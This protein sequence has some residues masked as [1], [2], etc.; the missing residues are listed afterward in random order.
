VAKG[1]T[2]FMPVEV[3]HHFYPSPPLWSALSSFVS[4]SMVPLIIIIS[5]A[6]QLCAMVDC[7]VPP[8]VKAAQEHKMQCI[9][10]LW[11]ANMFLS[12]M[13]NTGAFEITY[14]GHLIFSKLESGRMPTL[15]ELMQQL[16][17]LGVKPFDSGVGDFS[18]PSQ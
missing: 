2:Q 3:H 4:S 7:P 6:D 16:K 14:N 10:A 8:F 9:M 12:Q 17:V 18:L 5:F 1:I 15:P 13:C 11:I